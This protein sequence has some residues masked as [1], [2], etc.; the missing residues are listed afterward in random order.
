MYQEEMKSYRT[1]ARPAQEEPEMSDILA[2]VSEF[3][4]NKGCYIHHFLNE[5]IPHIKIKKH[6]IKGF[7]EGQIHNGKLRLLFRREDCNQNGKFAVEA[8]RSVLTH[9]TREYDLS[10]PNSLSHAFQYVRKY[11]FPPKR[12]LRGGI[13]DILRHQRME[14]PTP[15]PQ[16]SKTDS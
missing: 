5:T 11:L 6:G 4:R 8:A 15:S 12:K 10:H 3:F 14:R 7:V 2:G 9:G 1:T 16:T 13:G